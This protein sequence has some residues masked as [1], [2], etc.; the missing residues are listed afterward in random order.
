MRKR[1]LAAVMLI[2]LVGEVVA[3][4]FSAQGSYF[5]TGDESVEPEPAPTREPQPTATPE[6]TVEAPS[7]SEEEAP[8]PTGEGEGGTSI[9]PAPVYNTTNVYNQTFIYELPLAWSAVA[10]LR[11]TNNELGL[12]D[13]RMDHDTFRNICQRFNITIADEAGEQQSVAAKED[14]FVS[15]ERRSLAGLDSSGAGGEVIAV[16]TEKAWLIEH[17]IISSIEH[18]DLFSEMKS[19]LRVDTDPEETFFKFK[20]E[21]QANVVDK[22]VTLDEWFDVWVDI[23]KRNCRNSTI[24][25]YE[26]GYNRLRDSLGWR[27]LSTLNLLILQK[28]FNELD[29]DASRKY[30]KSLLVDMLSKAQGAGLITENVARK[31]NTV[32][33]GQPKEEKQILTEKEID[34]VLRASY[35]SQ[36]HSIFVIALHTGMRIGEILGLT[37][38]C[39]DFENNVIHITK[40]LCYLV[41]A[42]KS[43]HE[44]HQ[45]KTRAGN[46]KIPM[47]VEVKKV[48]EEEKKVRLSKD[49]KFPPQEGFEELVFTS[50]WNKPLNTPN[51]IGS[52][53]QLVDRINLN[54]PAIPLKRFTPHTLR[55]T[56]ASNCI[57]K[58]MRPKTLQKILGHN[59]LQMTMDLYCHVLDDTVKEE[60][61]EITEMV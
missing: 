36:L 22:D 12:Q 55:H 41:A 59:S 17:N 50:R 49:Q 10:G 14:L 29:S 46:R 4:A 23:Y 7:P 21:K 37:W 11:C 56:F 16:S 43:H 48:L 52:I 28:A 42:G 47:S 30:C 27:K 15:N 54:N 53:N 33:H 8:Q 19:Y 18:L 1:F 57:T 5:G 39:V 2:A 3:P 60:M 44:F 34:L 32:L 13:Y 38:D 26:F 45:P 20:D 51:I 6:P 58:G 61:S 25:T 31:I 24:R 9:P 35:G 40:T